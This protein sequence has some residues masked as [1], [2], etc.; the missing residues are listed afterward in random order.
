[1]TGGHWSEI[2]QVCEIVPLGGGYSCNQ[3]WKIR[4][5]KAQFVMKV[6]SDRS[7]AEIAYV[8]DLLAHLGRTCP[9]VPVPLAASNGRTVLPWEGSLATLMPLL[10]GTKANRAEPTHRKAAAVMLARIHAALGAFPEGAHRPGLPPLSALDWRVNRWWDWIRAKPYIE[11]QTGEI[12][13]AGG[14]RA[15]ELAD[16]WRRGCATR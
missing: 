11:S 1:M 14:W 9:Q 7:E 8:N 12:A 2:D 4:A 10:P 5:E 3:V 6:Y 13:G 15:G 16:L